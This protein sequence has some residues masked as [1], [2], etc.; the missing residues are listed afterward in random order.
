MPLI[1]KPTTE[2][3]E[4]HFFGSGAFQ[5]GWFDTIGGN[6]FPV[7]LIERDPETGEYIGEGKTI[8]TTDFTEGIKM[9]AESHPDKSFDDLIEG[10]DAY[11]VDCVFQ[12]M[13]FGE[14][15]YS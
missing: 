4:D 8:H 6:S 10:M 15:R 12:F 2:E 5:Y 14:I 11:D 7:V 1:R 9:Y 3:L 13:M